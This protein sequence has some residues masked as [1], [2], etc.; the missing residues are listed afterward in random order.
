MNETLFQ[1]AQRGIANSTLPD[2]FHISTVNPVLLS[3]GMTTVLWNGSV[4]VPP[5][6]RLWKKC[7]V[8]YGPS[9]TVGFLTIT[10]G[11]GSM[12]H[13]LLADSLNNR[14]VSSTVTG[15][16]PP[17]SKKFGKAAVLSVDVTLFEFLLVKSLIVCQSVF[18][19][20]GL[21]D[22]LVFLLFVPYHYV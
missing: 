2:T 11:T 16:R 8:M 21:R 14:T 20:I 3:N 1:D 15:N 6:S 12:Q 10:D 9:R 19:N 7:V 5:A 17:F 22:I 4:K 18:E 13:V